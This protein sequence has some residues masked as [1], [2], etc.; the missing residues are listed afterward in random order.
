[1]VVMTTLV[2]RVVG[3]MIK[4]DYYYDHSGDDYDH[5]GDD[6]DHGGDDYDQV[7]DDLTSV[8]SIST[9]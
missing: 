8:P 2:W 1:M 7:C 9:K 5:G 3:I 4:S 6:Y